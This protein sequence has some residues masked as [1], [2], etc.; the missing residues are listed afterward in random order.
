[1]KGLLY[2]D[3]YTMFKQYRYLVVIAVILG[4]IPGNSLSLLAVLYAAILPVSALA[5]DE[6]ALWHRMAA[7]MPLPR[8]QIVLSKYLLGLVCALGAAALGLVG[9]GVLAL[10]QGGAYGLENL[11][12]AWGMAGLALTMQALSMPV[13]FRFGVE[14]GR[15]CM[16]LVM[17]LFAAAIGALNALDV[18]R[19]SLAMANPAIL[20]F[21]ALPV[22]ALSAL[23]A[24]RVFEKREL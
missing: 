5:I 11:G 16:M 19:V 10:I 21:I 22:T 3:L 6:Q 13:M 9:E 20:G 17:A 4:L 7:V 24:V 23:V 15:L 2:K 8:W 1:M 14:K 12:K 18:Q